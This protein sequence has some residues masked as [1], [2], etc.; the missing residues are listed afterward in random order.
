M[1]DDLFFGNTVPRYSGLTAR[2]R[3]AWRTDPG[4]VE[5]YEE[6]R[7]S[8]RPFG[9]SRFLRA[10]E[11]RGIS[12][13]ESLVGA[14]GWI[15]PEWVVR[16]I[17][18]L[19]RDYPHR[20]IMDPYA[21]TGSLIAPLT[22]RI[23]P[24]RSL[25]V[26]RE[27]SGCVLAH[28][29]HPASPVEWLRTDIDTGEGF[30][31]LASFVTGEGEE[32]RNRIVCSAVMHLRGGGRC[33]LVIHGR[34]LHS[35]EPL[36]SGLSAAG[37]PLEVLLVLPWGVM[38]IGHKGSPSSRV[39]LG[40]LTHEQGVQ[41]TLA[42][43][44]LRREEGREP[45][46][47]MHVTR[48]QIWYPLEVIRERTIALKM[49]ETGA[50]PKALGEIAPAIRDY[51][52]GGFP[53]AANAIYVPADPESLVMTP[54]EV[55]ADPARYMQVVLD[56]DLADAVY[57]AGFLNTPQGREIR[58]LA[59]VR[60]G[61]MGAAA[62]LARTIV[63]LPP[64]EVQREV[65]SLQ[66][67]LAEARRSIEDV[68][69]EL[70]RHPLKFP[71][72]RRSVEEISRKGEIEGWME[73]LPFPLASIL[74]AWRAE[75]DAEAGT[76]HLFHFFEAASQFIAI[77]MLSAVGP[78]STEL[79]VD[80]LEDDPRFRDSFRFASYRAW[81]VLGRRL[82]RQTRKF[83]S[84]SEMREKCLLLYGDPEPEFLET[85]TRKRIFAILDEGA[86]LRNLWKAHGGVVGKEEAQSRL[87]ELEELLNEFRQA[88]GP[89]F[90]GARLV[91]PGSGEYHE[92][93]FC[94]RAEDLGGTRVPFRDVAIRTVVP[95]DSGH[96]YLF[97]RDYSAPLLL[98][99]LVRIEKREE[100]CPACYFYNRIEDGQTRWI[101]YHFTQEPELFT[102][103]Q[104]IEEILSR[105][106]LIAQGKR[107]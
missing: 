90:T 35:E 93:I 55:P 96:L 83:L 41:D 3:D 14:E 28:C 64:P 62:A 10:A 106:G 20:M 11:E 101:S 37:C 91:D 19:A 56:P 58:A 63:Y 40:E 44:I 71:E 27:P 76:D 60:M 5:L 100:G 1:W 53:A 81:N 50:A 4:L 23:S 84:L 98:L 95:L 51:G 85:I 99:P 102:P 94:Y 78:L 24:E 17:S 8:E 54:S 104:E 57:L 86:D 48:D 25:G 107:P 21:S 30:E 74:W 38:I 47:G 61:R 103:A 69:H 79:G 34:S 22:T 72:L 73:T 80:L 13:P 12:L 66:A 46:L 89:L 33:V 97:F 32:E 82:A 18:L 45:P 87:S 39:F 70:W 59:R 7:E 31:L 15:C 77:I 92:G 2:S 9:V 26:C 6:F 67:M 43:N 88:I 52:R 29:L 68:Q 16:F 42:M 49:K 36:I 65:I 75:G 105:F